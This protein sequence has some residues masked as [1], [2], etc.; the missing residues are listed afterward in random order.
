MGNQ[1]NNC[2]YK[3]IGQNLFPCE[4]RF[5]QGNV[6]CPYLRLWREGTLTTFPVQFQELCKPCYEKLPDNRKSRW[7]TMQDYDKWMKFKTND[8]KNQ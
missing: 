5:I 6:Y 3:T 2:H 1:Q 7:F 4:S 8:I